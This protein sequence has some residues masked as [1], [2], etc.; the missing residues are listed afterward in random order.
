M[1]G[2]SRTPTTASPERVLLSASRA[3]A[4]ARAHG[5]VADDP[6][7]LAAGA[8]L[9]VHLRPLPVV[10]KVAA[11]THEVREPAEWLARELAVAGHLAARGIPVVRPSEEL[12]PEVHRDGGAVMTFWRH[13]RHDPARVPRPAE[14]A[15]LL[16]D[17][18]VALR[19]CAEP[20]PWLGPPLLDTARFLD[21]ARRRRTLPADHLDALADAFDDLRAALPA[22]AATD[23]PL[24]GDPHPGNLLSTPAGWLWADLEDACSGPL[25]WDLAC[26]DSSVRTDGRAAVRAYGVDPEELGVFRGLRRLHTTVWYCLYAET[27]PASRARAAELLRGWDAQPPW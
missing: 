13:E 9:V 24:H 18:H 6:V 27:D 15:A 16:A 8:N 5:L 26:V 25:W 2:G 20:L 11:V 17:L 22:A 14:M 1:P 7:V 4:V 12:P 21:R 3:V 19:D 23:Q 10:A